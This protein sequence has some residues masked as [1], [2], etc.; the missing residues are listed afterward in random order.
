LPVPR[1]QEAF[2][3]EGVPRDLAWNQRSERFLAEFEW[4]ARAL[5]AERHRGLPY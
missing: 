3:P 2:D 4:Y 5:K 1:V